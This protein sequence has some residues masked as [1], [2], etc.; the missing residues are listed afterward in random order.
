MVIII[1]VNGVL[2]AATIGIG[3][4]VARAML[5]AAAT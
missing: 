5:E 3:F 1:V 4:F 2:L